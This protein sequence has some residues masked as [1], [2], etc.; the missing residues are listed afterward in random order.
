MPKKR[1]IAALDVGSHEITL[2]IAQLERNGLPLELETVKQTLAIGTDTYRTGEIH[3]DTVATLVDV[4]EKMVIK[5]KEYKVTQVSAA[6]TSAIREAR[7]RQLVLDQIDRVCRYPIQVLSNAQER[8]FHMVATISRWPEFSSKIQDG[9]LVLEGQ[10]ISAPDLRERL[11]R[12]AAHYKDVAV[13]LRGDVRTPY[14]NIVGVL[15][16]CREA[17]I[18]NVAFATN[19]PDAE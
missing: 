2:K 10:T 19:R 1:T 7:N 16:L 9:T 12:V 17:G 13:I 15:D 8:Y 4:L 14:E 5:L 6:A 3:N 11:G 18:W